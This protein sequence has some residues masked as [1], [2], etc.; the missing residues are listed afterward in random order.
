MPWGPPTIMGYSSVPLFR[1]R[2]S[3]IRTLSKSQEKPTA[4]GPFFSISSR[5]APFSMKGPQV[6]TGLFQAPQVKEPH[7]IMGAGIVLFRYVA[8]KNLHP[9]TFSSTNHEQPV[10]CIKGLQGFNDSRPQLFLRFPRTVFEPV[11]EDRVMAAMVLFPVEYFST[12]YSKGDSA[13]PL[14]RG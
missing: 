7:I 3:M 13:S 8:E 12:S 14:T 1:D 9:V 5:N 6:Q 10:F 2:S 4:R 11:M